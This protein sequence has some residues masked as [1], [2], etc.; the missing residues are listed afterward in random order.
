MF[1]PARL[2]SYLYN[3]TQNS[4]YSDAA[5]LAI[6]FMRNFVSDGNTPTQDGF[7]LAHCTR[8][9]SN[10]FTYNSGYFIEGLAAYT[11]LTGD[12]SQKD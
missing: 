2:S 10:N 6:G 5:N 3:A 7:N 12:S 8:G 1:R 11:A 4:T 9:I